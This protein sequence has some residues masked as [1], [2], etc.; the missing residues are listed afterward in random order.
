VFKGG[1]Q[2]KHKLDYSHALKNGYFWKF[3]ADVN[4]PDPEGTLLEIPTYTKMVFP[5]QMVTR[6]R[7]SLQQK[8]YSSNLTLKTKMN[9]FR[10]LMRIR[11][12]LKLDFCRMNLNELIGMLNHVINEDKNEPET[13]KPIVLIGHTKDLDDSDTIEQFL[14]YLKNTDIRISTLKEVYGRCLRKLISKSY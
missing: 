6:K 1:F 12:P 11:Q 13:F 7:F 10:D 14:H 3:S 2:H 8:T 4:K 9:R 5:W